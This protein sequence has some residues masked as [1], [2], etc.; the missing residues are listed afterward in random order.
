MQCS[1]PESTAA[2]ASPSE[3]AHSE[4]WGVGAGIKHSERQSHVKELGVL[5]APCTVI[6]GL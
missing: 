5:R 3:D 4:V 6:K 1:F 2:F